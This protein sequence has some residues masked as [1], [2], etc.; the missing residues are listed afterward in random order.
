MT[1]NFSGPFNFSVGGNFLHYETEEN[2]Y[3]FINGLNLFTVTEGDH[4][5]SLP[6]MFQVSPITTNVCQNWSL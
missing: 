6:I 2:Y 3:V 1:S 4:A 5:F